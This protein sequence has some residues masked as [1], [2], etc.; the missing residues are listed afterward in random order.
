[1]YGLSRD[2]FRFAIIVSS[3]HFS[4]HVYYRILPP[5]IPVLAV[6]LE[7]PLWQLGLLI[8]IYS[9][10]MGVTQAPLGM[11]SDKIDRNYLL[12]PGIAL[13]GAAYLLF[14]ISPLLAEPIPGVTIA[15]YAFEG[16]FL[17][18]SVSMIFVGVGLSVVHPTGYPL[19]SDN[20][21]AS[22]KGKVLGLFGASSKFGDAATP[23]I[24]AGLIILL[25]WQTIILLF[26]GFGI[27]YGTALYVVLRQDTYVTKPAGARVEQESMEKK[28]E[29][30][31]SRTFLYPMLAMY[32]FFVA[33][34]VGIQAINTFLPTFIV[35]VYE[36]TV[37][38]GGI[39]L[40]A[41]SV[42]NLYFAMLLLSGGIMQLILGGVTDAK[43]PRTVLLWCMIAATVG[44]V[45]LALVPVSPLSL[46]FVIILLGAGLNG[47]NPARDAL[48]S[49]LSP[50][51]HEGRT[52]GYFFTVGSLVAA[53][54]PAL[55]GYLLD[56]V[57]M[58]T[59]YLLLASGPF[60]AV[61][62]IA[63]LYSDRVYKKA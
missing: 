21:P 61:L 7:Y 42:A 4:Q 11:L 45:F 52:F 53:P 20:I 37:E 54:M 6:A 24:V 10:G 57:G 8:S 34:M 46:I 62:C 33:T 15:G 28:R 18:M 56:T 29:K 16:G 17:L 22:Q 19:I 3:A 47:L 49:T 38:I 13:T 2:E 23:T 58:R 41:E 50:A 60:V 44:M 9:F 26:G 43:E 12:A 40:G 25:D 55:I 51:E 39:N 35:E 63:L 36:Y 5:L 48:I 59:G 1:M 14:A 32:G 27:L 30:Q 31:D